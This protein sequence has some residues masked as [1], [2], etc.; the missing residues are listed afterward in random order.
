M[1]LGTNEIKNKDTNTEDPFFGKS[2][3]I[4]KPLEKLIRRKK[5]EKTNNI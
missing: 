3:K 4:N 1:T 5:R 2:N